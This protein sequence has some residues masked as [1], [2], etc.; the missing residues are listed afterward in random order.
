LVFVSRL[1]LVFSSDL[2]PI[3]RLD[4]SCRPLFLSL[5]LGSGRLGS[6]F[7]SADDGRFVTSST[8]AAASTAT[9][10]TTRF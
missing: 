10:P 4:R 8:P 6:P 7:R 5:V 1:V 3:G 9:T 2:R